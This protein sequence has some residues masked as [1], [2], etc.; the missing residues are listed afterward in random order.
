MRDADPHAARR[1]YSQATTHLKHTSAS[2]SLG[3]LGFKLVY[4]SCN[5]PVPNMDSHLFPLLTLRNRERMM[6]EY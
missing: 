6:T 2:V 5:Y 1:M 4:F 3:G